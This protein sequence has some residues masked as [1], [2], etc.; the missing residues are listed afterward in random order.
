MEFER[1]HFLPLLSPQD[2]LR[3]VKILKGLHPK[4]SEILEVEIHSGNRIAHVTEGWPDAG[5][6]VVALSKPFNKVYTKE[7]IVFELPNDPHY[8]KQGYAT[9]SPAHLL[10]C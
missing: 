10:A 6:I 1:H 9:T 4:L 7:G 2:V 3:F 5:S 8:W